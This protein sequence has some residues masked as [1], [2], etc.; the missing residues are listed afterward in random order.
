MSELKVSD[1]LKNSQN[2]NPDLLERSSEINE[3]LK[4]LGHKK[5]GYQL[6]CRRIKVVDVREIA[7]DRLVALSTSD[8]K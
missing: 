1:L 7:T 8:N 2:I 6:G 5:P 4:R 3:Q